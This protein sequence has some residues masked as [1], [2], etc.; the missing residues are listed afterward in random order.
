M[1]NIFLT[2]DT[3]FSHDAIRRYCNRP[4]STVEEMDETLI[5]NWNNIVRIS[6]VVYV[7]GDFA[8]RDHRKFLNK[9]NGK[10][11]LIIGNH[12]DVSQYKT[13]DFLEIH[14]LL[15]RKIDGIQV[16]M[17]H[18]SMKTWRNSCHGSWHFYGHSHQKLPESETSWS[19][20][21]GVDGW[22]FTPVPWEVAKERMYNTK[23]KL[24]FYP[25]G[26]RDDTHERNKTI[27]MKYIKKYKEKN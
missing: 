21:V 5:E 25:C 19:F 11:I 23:N 15:F 14:D 7:L 18:Y 1:E 13:G 22:D 27:N 12:D 20:D 24:K 17:C 26:E 2:A 6:D 3:H 8:R 9:L 4:F 16:I 10:K